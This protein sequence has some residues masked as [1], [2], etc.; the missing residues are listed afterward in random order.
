LAAESD[1]I[2]LAYVESELGRMI[3][4][5]EAETGRR[6][7]RDRLR[8]IVRL[9]NDG[10]TLWA[11]ILYQ[12]RATPCPVTAADIFTHMFPMVALRGTQAY[13]RHLRG[14]R[15]ESGARVEQGFAAVPG[16]RYRLLWDNLPLWFDLKIFDELAQKGANFVTDTY[17]QAWGLATWVRS[18]RITRCGPLPSR[19]APGS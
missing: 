16:E 2:N 1:G 19:W 17:T 3:T 7:D 15:D 8:E 6:L 9:S 12:R 18:T 11:E 4:W 10:R 13:V 14:L 5:V